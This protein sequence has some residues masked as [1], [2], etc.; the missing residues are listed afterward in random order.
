MSKIAG[1]AIVLAVPVIGEFDQRRLASRGSLGNE[2][3]VARRSEEHQREF[4]LL[5]DPAPDF[6]E[7]ELVAVEIKCC[8]EIANAQHGVQI[9][10]GWT[11]TAVS[12]SDSGQS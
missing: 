4:A 12:L 1:F 10:H 11:S 9:S 8:V 2:I 6:L 7:A 5:V 3:V